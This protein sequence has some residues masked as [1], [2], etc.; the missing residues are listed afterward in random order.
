MSLFFFKKRGSVLK[1]QYILDIQ[2][3][4]LIQRAETK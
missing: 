4:S 2:I 3:N 1:N